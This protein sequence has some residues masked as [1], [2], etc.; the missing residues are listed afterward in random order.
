MRPGGKQAPG[1][2]ASEQSPRCEMTL[3]QARVPCVDGA[4]G[5][6]CVLELY[7]K[8]LAVEAGVAGKERVWK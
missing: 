5:V 1:E 2:A 3:A 7:S 8:D 4:E 6:L